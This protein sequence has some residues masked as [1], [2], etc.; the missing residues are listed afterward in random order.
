MERSV[1]TVRTEDEQM[2]RYI[3]TVCTEGEQ[4]EQYDDTA[5]CFMRVNKWG[6]VM[7]LLFV[8]RVGTV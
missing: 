4:I 2:E 5:L 8:Y 1:V 6:D 3:N 7:I